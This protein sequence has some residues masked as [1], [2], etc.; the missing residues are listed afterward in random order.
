MNQV[1]SDVDT[2][3]R[4]DMTPMIDCVFLMIVFF[5]CIDFRTLEAKL[6]AYL[7]KERGAGPSRVEPQSSLSIGVYERARGER[8]IPGGGAGAALAWDP[9]TGRRPRFALRGHSVRWD[10]GPIAIDD[11]PALAAQLVRICADRS[12]W[13]DDPQHPGQKK[14]LRVVIEPHPGVYYD[15]VAATTD[16]VRAAGF[17]EVDFGGGMGPR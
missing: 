3:A 7:P 11:Y 14:P 17:T 15:D 4:P 8:T 13:Q 5:V 2:E 1:A 9:G 16:A 12:T 6:P 10:V